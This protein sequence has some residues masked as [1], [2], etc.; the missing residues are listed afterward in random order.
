MR[1]VRAVLSLVESHEG[2]DLVIVTHGAVGTLLWCHFAGNKIERRFDQPG[3][4][5]YWCAD[6]ETRQPECE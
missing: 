3:Q 6:I 1:I 5:H 2:R 4:G